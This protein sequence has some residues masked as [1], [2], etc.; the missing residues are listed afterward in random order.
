VVVQY[1]N[2]AHAIFLPQWD[3]VVLDELILVKEEKLACASFP[4]WWDDVV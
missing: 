4:P 2:L 1:G 3:D